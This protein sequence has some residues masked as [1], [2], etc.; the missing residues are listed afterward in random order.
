MAAGGAGW[1]FGSGRYTPVPSVLGQDQPTAEATLAT[2]DLKAAV[3][4]SVYSEDVPAGLG[5]LHRPRARAW[6]R[7][8][9]AR[10]TLVL[11]LGPERYA[12]PELA[13]LTADEA[14]AAL[15]DTKLALGPVAEE[16]SETVE[17]RPDHPVRPAGGHLVEAADRPCRCG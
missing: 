2:A 6:T 13:N 17:A 7:G 5:H 10:S 15:E 14:R 12:V 8:E 1:W 16:Y 11:S 9:A 4:E 3:S